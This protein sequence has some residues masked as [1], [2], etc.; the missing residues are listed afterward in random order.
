MRPK[1][2]DFLERTSS[3]QVTSKESF[4]LGVLLGTD[5]VNDVRFSMHNGTD[6]GDPEVIPSC[7]YDA[8]ALGMNGVMLPFNAYCPDGIYLNV[9]SGSNYEIVTFYVD[10]EDAHAARDWQF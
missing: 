5:G 4:L 10:L 9:E 8:S 2:A 7:T 1:R 3:G 6:N